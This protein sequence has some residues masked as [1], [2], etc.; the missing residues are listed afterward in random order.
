MRL[1]SLFPFFISFRRAAGRGVVS[2]Q[3]GPSL[4]ALTVGPLSPFA[5]SAAISGAQPPKRPL[6][7]RARVRGRWQEMA[8]DLQPHAGCEKR[9]SCRGAL[10]PFSKT[11]EACT[12]GSEGQV[13]VSSRLASPPGPV[14]SCFS[15]ALGGHGSLLPIPLPEQ[16]LD[17]NLVPRAREEKLYTA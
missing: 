10:C 15:A 8:G 16:D 4:I 1:P 11:F 9:I 5:A 12:V 13:I 2:L 7:F 14:E 3:L 6:E 17:I